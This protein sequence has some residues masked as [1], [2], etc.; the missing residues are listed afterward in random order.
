VDQAAVSLPRR[1]AKL[2]G[3]ARGLA[4][5]RIVHPFPTGL[6][7]AATA[8]LA[9]IAAGDD[10]D[11]ALLARMLGAMFLIQSTIG[12]ANDIFDCELDAASKPYKPL[13]SG[14][15]SMR[16]AR[17]LA[18]VL[19]SGAVALSATLGAAGFALAMLGLACGL[20]YDARLKRTV[21]SA[22]PFMIAIPTLPL[23]VWAT[24]DEWA[25][26]LWWLAPL[27]A[28]IGL[29]LHLANTLPDIEEDA[30]HGVRGLAHALG[31]RYSMVLAWSAFA[32][33]LI[34]AAAIAPIVGYDARL[35]ITTL[36]F[37][38]ACLAASIAAWLLRRDEL[39]L[40][41]A[42]GIMA[43]GAAVTATGWLAAVT[44]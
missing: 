16:A 22:V 11:A 37:G 42:F 10:L 18:L 38:A 5:L 14:A 33:A 31:K 15:V 13:V 23:W 20:S 43:V 1:P 4:V 32:T 3:K 2:S 27:G 28:L 24:L 25:S 41:I 8:A 34:I 17:W 6:N 29:A 44:Y 26:V 39:S 40:R 21:F 7:V 30:A 19:L 12:V 9:V 36:A 35:I